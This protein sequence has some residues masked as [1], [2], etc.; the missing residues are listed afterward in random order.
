MGRL[1][2]EECDGWALP[3]V[4]MAAEAAARTPVAWPPSACPWCAFPFLCSLHLLGGNLDPLS[5]PPTGTL[6]V[7]GQHV[8]CKRVLKDCLLLCQHVV[9]MAWSFRPHPF[10]QDILHYF[11]AIDEHF[12]GTLFSSGL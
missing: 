1:R 6:V 11:S 4:D 10:S 2:G 12:T 5:E 9:P 8:H 3:E 7:F